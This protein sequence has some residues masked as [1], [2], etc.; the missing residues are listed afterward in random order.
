[1][2]TG[3]VLERLDRGSSSVSCH[4]P[5]QSC[6][7]PSSCGAPCVGPFL[8]PALSD[9]DTLPP[10][11]SEVRGAAVLRGTQ[12]LPPLRSIER[13]PEGQC[14]STQSNLLPNPSYRGHES[15]LHSSTQLCLVLLL[16]PA[17][18]EAQARHKLSPSSLTKERQRSTPDGKLKL[19]P[20]PPSSA[21]W[22]RAP[23]FTFDPE[24]IRHPVAQP[25]LQPQ[26]SRSS[27]LIRRE[28]CQVVPGRCQSVP[29]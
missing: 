18:V 4:L 24:F 10:S 6:C 9:Y 23:S 3:R 22:H 26:S 12:C 21:S 19:R 7:A 5:A 15:T 20:E 25:Q 8:G 27:T 29:G 2:L 1:M 28:A 17:S 14:S 16:R 13:S 11:E